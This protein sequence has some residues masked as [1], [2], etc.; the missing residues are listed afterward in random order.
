MFDLC[1]TMN[2]EPVLITAAPIGGTQ[3]TKGGSVYADYIEA[4]RLAAARSKVMIADANAAMTDF[5]HGG[6]VSVLLND[7]WH[8][9]DIGHRIYFE[10]SARA[11][12]LLE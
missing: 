1:R 7:N 9:N 8:P 12:G 11:A 5:I 4:S 2:A 10:A 3:V 6:D